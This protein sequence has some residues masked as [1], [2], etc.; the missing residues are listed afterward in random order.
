MHF[1]TQLSLK[2]FVRG[3]HFKLS[4]SRHALYRILTPPRGKS[5]WSPRPWVHVGCAPH[6]YRFSGGGGG[7]G[8]G[9]R[10]PKLLRSFSLAQSPCG[11]F[12][13]DLEKRVYGFD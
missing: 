6:I 5:W 1:L 2:S 12:A 4:L 3:P 7:G 9:R 10:P 13:D 8:I 11:R